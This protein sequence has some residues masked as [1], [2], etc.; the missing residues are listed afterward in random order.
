MSIN[1]QKI[2]LDLPIR[3]RLVNEYPLLYLDSAATSQ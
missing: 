1:I 2:R 3:S